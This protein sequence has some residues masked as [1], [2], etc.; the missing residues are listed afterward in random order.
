MITKHGCRKLDIDR[1][2]GGG[3][4]DLQVQETMSII[5]QKRRPEPSQVKDNRE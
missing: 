3:W 2:R 1:G 5:G 4:G